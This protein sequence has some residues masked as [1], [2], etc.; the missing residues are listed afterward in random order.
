MTAHQLKQLTWENTGKIPE[1]ITT[2]VAPCGCVMSD[3][4]M[5]DLLDQ[6]DQQELHKY[7]YNPEINSKIAGVTNH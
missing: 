4:T 5:T 2:M 6:L 3:N 7:Q 1:G